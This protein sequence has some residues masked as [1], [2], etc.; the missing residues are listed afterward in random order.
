MAEAKDVKAAFQRELA[1]LVKAR[2][3][4]KHQVEQARNDVRDEWKKLEN[5]WQAVEAEIKRV[6]E[7]RASPSRICRWRPRTWSVSFAGASIGSRRRSSR[8]SRPRKG[9]TPTV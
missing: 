6:S 2:D 5:T 9:P 4:L 7:R 1:G 8:T 3:E